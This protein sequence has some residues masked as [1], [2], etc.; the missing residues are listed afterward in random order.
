[1]SM[2][3]EGGEGR[4]GN[5]GNREIREIREIGEIRGKCKMIMGVEGEGVKGKRIGIVGN[6]SS[7]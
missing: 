3:N 4:E 1:M 7:P 6:Y 2:K 5:R